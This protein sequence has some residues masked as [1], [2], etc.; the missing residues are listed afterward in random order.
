MRGTMPFGVAPSDGGLS[1]LAWLT[2]ASELDRDQ[3][4]RDPDPRAEVRDP[5]FVLG[6]VRA[7]VCARPCPSST[8][9]PEA[10]QTLPFVTH[11]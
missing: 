4:E 10:A 5:K 6:E 1:V 9:S 3:A 7:T 11:L 8:R 2:T